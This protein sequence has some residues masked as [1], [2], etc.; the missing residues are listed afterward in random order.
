[1]KHLDLRTPIRRKTIH[2]TTLFVIL[3]A[4]RFVAAS[5]EGTDDFSSGIFTTNWLVRSC[6]D[7]GQMLVAG[8]NGH[9][10][11]LV[12]N[13]ASV[14][15]NAGLVWR[16]LPPAANDWTADIL[17][18][19]IAGWSANGRSEFKFLVLD[20]DPTGTP[21]GEFAIRM[22]LGAA[23]LNDPYPRDFRTVYSPGPSGVVRQIAQTTATN[24]SAAQFYRLRAN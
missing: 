2:V 23:D 13:S 18:H 22:S 12:P 19:N 11:F 21:V 16:G 6:L 7:G 17:G 20:I 9:G 5:W 1:M 14:E 10:S 3:A 8:T 4:N 24:S 15:Q